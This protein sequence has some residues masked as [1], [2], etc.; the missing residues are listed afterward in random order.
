[1]PAALNAR[2]F[3][4]MQT[5]GN[6]EGYVCVIVDDMVDTAGTLV[7]ACELLKAMGASKVVACA[8]HG[9]LTDPACDRVNSCAALDTLVVTDSIPQARNIE[10]VEKLV[11]LSIA[12][13][14]GQAIQRVHREESISELF[15]SKQEKSRPVAAPAASA[16]AAPSA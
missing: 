11:V 12:P 16:A 2:T 9:I 8:S 6:V 13:L 10:R 3:W 15:P 4:R 7:K 5:V 14:L 1:M